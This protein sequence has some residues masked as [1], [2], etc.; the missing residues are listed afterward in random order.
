M[1]SAGHQS[2]TAVSVTTPAPV[3]PG[4]PD[5]SRLASLPPGAALASALESIEPADVSDF[6]LVEVI[7]ACERQSSWATARQLAAIA[8]LAGRTVLT[9]RRV[10]ARR[11]AGMEVSARLRLSPST[12]EHRVL[13][14]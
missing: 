4:A 14:A 1:A 6:D 3:A 13:I 7:A 5:L 9:G 2:P 11:L 12:A 8:E 10:A